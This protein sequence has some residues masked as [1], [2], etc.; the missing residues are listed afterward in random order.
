MS[1]SVRVMR[2]GPGLLVGIPIIALTVCDCGLVTNLPV[3]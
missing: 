3:S 1:D 2:V